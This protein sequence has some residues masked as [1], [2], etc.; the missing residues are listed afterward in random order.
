[1]DV[2]CCDAC[3]KFLPNNKVKQIPD[4]LRGRRIELCEEC[5]EKVKKLN[6]EFDKRC[7]EERNAQKNDYI[8]KMKELGVEED[9]EWSDREV[10]KG[11]RLKT[12]KKSS[13]TWHTKI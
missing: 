13:R 7:E 2:R 8:E 3:K 10:A 4:M 11:W 9:V 1:M 6:E 12:T 5:Y